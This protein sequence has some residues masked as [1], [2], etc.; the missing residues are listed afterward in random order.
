MR[1][2]PLVISDTARKTFMIVCS[3]VYHPTCTCVHQVCVT[4]DSVEFLLGLS[5]YCL[6]INLILC[7]YERLQFEKKS[8][9]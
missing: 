8:H 2:I 4:V 7:C 1:F 6:S 3:Y 5:D 9:L